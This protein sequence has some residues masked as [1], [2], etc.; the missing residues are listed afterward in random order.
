[1][2][3]GQTETFDITTYIPPKDFKKDSKQGV[4]TYTN[5]N[6]TTGGFC[7]IVMYASTASSGDAERDFKK[8]WKELVAT[9]FK[10]EANHSS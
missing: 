6:T 9:P 5:V 7:V 1:V 8:E 10:A 2:V 4:A 3:F